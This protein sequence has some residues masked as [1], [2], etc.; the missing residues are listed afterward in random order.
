MRPSGISS[1]TIRCGAACIAALPLVASVGFFSYKNAEAD[2][3]RVKLE[4]AI[5]NHNLFCE[6]VIGENYQY[7]PSDCE[8]PPPPPTPVS[9]DT[10]TFGQTGAGFTNL[11]SSSSGSLTGTGAGTGTSAATKPPAEQDPPPPTRPVTS[12]SSSDAAMSAASKVGIDGLVNVAPF[13]DRATLTF[14]TFFPSLLTISW[15]KTAMYEQGA[16]AASSYRQNFSKEVTGLEPGIR[17]YYRLDL[18]DTL[19]RRVSYEGSFL[20]A[21]SDSRA[22]LPFAVD[23]IN[24]P[25][26][27]PDMLE[28]SWNVKPGFD[29]VN[30][31]IDE[32]FLNNMAT[33]P[34]A[35]YEA[36]RQVF[37][38]LVRSDFSFPSDPFEGKVIY[39]GAGDHAVD[40]SLVS[41]RKYFYALFLMDKKGNYSAPAI[42]SHD[43]VVSLK[44]PASDDAA[45]GVSG[46]GKVYDPLIDDDSAFVVGVDTDPKEYPVMCSQSQAD[47]GAISDFSYEKIKFI[48][49]GKE[50][51]FKDGKVT[52][53]GTKKV[54]IKLE[55]GDLEQ[56]DVAGACFFSH[57]AEQWNYYILT[58]NSDGSREVIFP[59]LSSVFSGKKYYQFVI[60]V[61]KY[62]GEIETLT[63]GEI[64]F[65]IPKS[66]AGFSLK[67]AILGL[68]IFG[69]IFGIFKKKKARRS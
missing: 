53:D 69:L 67:L 25:G 42:I 23:L 27:D 19:K 30:K 47:M 24:R 17:Y 41:G 18:L 62:K 58:R 44:K 61:L 33:E 13:V 16:S 43:H 37:A 20:T 38:R 14:R 40:V 4:V 12:A 10:T 66:R 39:E 57:Y 9:P 29:T 48:Q 5:C 28:F 51:P 1:L 55:G 35:S 64:I 31:D 63:H 2:S 54:V 22:R 45:A 46:K 15:G 50:M 32:I 26:A 56:K 6:D 68:V 59:A 34:A 21:F 52:V 8:A 3:F 7:C 65:D 49:D 36:E 60:G 11:G